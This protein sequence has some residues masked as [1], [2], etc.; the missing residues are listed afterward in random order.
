[1]QPC[2]GELSC[3][4]CVCMENSGD[5]GLAALN[6]FAGCVVCVWGTLYLSW[7]VFIFETGVSQDFK[8]WTMLIL[9]SYSNCY[10]YTSVLLNYT[11]IKHSL[12][13]F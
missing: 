3:F 5:W 12:V 8:I 10:T 1:M 4:S 11:N 13:V 6:I 9:A 7:K 2:A